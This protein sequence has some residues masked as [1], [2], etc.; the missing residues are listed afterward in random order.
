MQRH[1]LA[2]VKSAILK[3]M[4]VHGGVGYV[5]VSMRGFIDVVNDSFC[6]MV[7]LTADR[8]AN[9]PVADLVALPARPHFREKME[10]VLRGGGDM[11]FATQFLS[12]DGSFV[13]IDAAIARLQGIYGTEGAVIVMTPTTGA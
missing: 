3:A 1:R 2:D 12:N 13:P 11:R 4:G 5:R 9:V 10:L 6:A 7:G 8:L